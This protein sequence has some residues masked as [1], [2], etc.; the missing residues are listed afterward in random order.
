ML[1]SVSA[2]DIIDKE[3]ADSA[4]VVTP[5]YS[6]ETFLACSIPDLKFDAPFVHFDYSGTKF[7]ADCVL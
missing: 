1:E 5:T 2:G 6:A 7:Y 4:A 3:G